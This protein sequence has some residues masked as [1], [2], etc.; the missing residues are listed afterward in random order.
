MAEKRLDPA[1]NSEDVASF[2]DTICP[3]RVVAEW[4]AQK[5]HRLFPS[6]RLHKVRIWVFLALKAVLQVD[7]QLIIFSRAAERDIA[8]SLFGKGI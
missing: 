3:R 4:V 1:E 5:L 8:S 7:E 2:R 6:K